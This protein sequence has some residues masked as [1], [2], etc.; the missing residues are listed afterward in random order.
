MIAQK[1]YVQPMSM[2]PQALWAKQKSVSARWFKYLLTR[3]GENLSSGTVRNL[4]AAV[5]YLELG[6]WMRARGYKLKYRVDRR[7]K[8]FDM[9]GAQVS[10]R[11]V[12]YMEFG[13]WQGEATRYWSKLLHNPK[14]KLHGFDSF[15]GLPE[16]W[17]TYGKGGFSVEGRVPQIDDARVQFFKGWFEQTLP[18]Y[19]FPSHEVLVLNFDADLYS[20]T[21]LAL[22]TVR[23]AIVPGTYLYF[24]DFN[25]PLH[26]VRAFDE[27][28]EETKMKFE[29][30]GATSTFGNVLF[31]RTR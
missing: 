15:E 26:E 13:V 28:V 25:Q 31:Q 19:E 23:D 11:D 5:N 20:S 21:R 18:R 17:N 27:F 9:V 24:D 12:L 4:N 16:T 6:R 22:K 14:S 10:E 29:L 2:N 1:G 30:L 8:L 3:G 7:E